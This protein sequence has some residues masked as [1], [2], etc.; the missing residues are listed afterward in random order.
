[1]VHAAALSPR[2]SQLNSKLRGS[3]AAA[4]LTTVSNIK[5][6]STSTTRSTTLTVR[7]SSASTQHDAADIHRISSLISEDNMSVKTSTSTSSRASSCYTSVTLRAVSYKRE[8]CKKRPWRRNRINNSRAAAAPMSSSPSPVASGMPSKV[9]VQIVEEREPSPTLPSQARQDVHRDPIEHTISSGDALVQ[10]AIEAKNAKGETTARRRSSLLSNCTVD[11]KDENDKIRDKDDDDASAI[12]SLRA[13]VQHQR[14]EISMHKAK[15]RARRRLDPRKAATNDKVHYEEL[16]LPDLEDNDDDDDEAILDDISI[17]D[18][19]S[20]P[21]VDMTKHRSSGVFS[22]DEVIFDADDDMDTCMSPL[23]LTPGNYTFDKPRSRGIP[24]P[25]AFEGKVMVKTKKTKAKADK[26][27]SSEPHCSR[28]DVHTVASKSEAIDDTSPRNKAPEELAADTSSNGTHTA[29]EGRDEDEEEDVDSR[30]STP[31]RSRLNG[32]P[33][34][35]DCTSTPLTQNKGTV[36]SVANRISKSVRRDST[37]HSTLDS[38][39]RNVR[40]GLLPPSFRETTSFGRDEYNHQDLGRYHLQPSSSFYS[41]T[42]TNDDDTSC[43]DSRSC[44]SYSEYGPH[45]SE[46]YKTLQS[47]LSEDRDAAGKEQIILQSILSE[48]DSSDSTSSDEQQFR[49]NSSLL[50]L[51]GES[52]DVDEDDDMSFRPP[53]LLNVDSEELDQHRQNKENGMDSHTCVLR[54]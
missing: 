35:G 39:G 32:I 7:S 3:S 25:L 48:D 31:L 16:K 43:T 34:D 8:R 1:M 12:Q 26:S 17:S 51:I 36:A 18:L 41:N 21:D 27:K 45:T 6:P 49:S 46:E 11:G 30:Y 23:E 47:I 14:R 50:D 4:E 10:K 15:E 13:M 24:P 22:I 44:Y 37:S 53:S 28:R 54:Y 33:E 5:V 19:A 9:K 52:D 20:W 40:S 42:H 38:A 29:T 2:A